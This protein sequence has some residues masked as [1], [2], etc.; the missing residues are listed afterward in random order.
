MYKYI[1]DSIKNNSRC[2][3]KGLTRPQQKAL[4]E[5]VRGL[6]TAGEPILRHIAQDSTKP[7]K[8]QAEKYSYHLG[9]V[10][11]Q[12]KVEELALKQAQKQIRKRKIIAYDL[13]DIAKESARKI[14][15]LSRV[16]DGSKRKTTTGFSLHGVGINGILTKFQVHDSDRFTLNQVRR[17]IVTEISEKLGKKGIWVIDRGNDHKHYFKFLRQDLKADF[18]ARL[19]SNRQVVL[20]KT[21]VKIQVKN[22][23]AGKYAVYL[24]RKNNDHVDLSCEY[25]L[26]I[27]NH[28]EGKE[29]IRLLHSLKFRYSKNQ[30]L[31]MYLQRWGVENIFKR[32]KE[33][34]DLESIRVLKWQKFVNLVALIQ[35]A[36]LVS[37]MM[38]LKIQ[39][40]TNALIIGVLMHYKKFMKLKTLG[41]NLD[42][43]ISFMQKSLKPLLF[44]L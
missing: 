31:N 17:K 15:K 28:L 40:S 30:I 23:Q 37:T 32:V 43:F 38:F 12:E 8:K 27:S 19:K 18:I 20:K 41:F 7:A 36:V 13:T 25:T 39:Q 16:W 29:L 14:E 42:S 6:F 35:L 44:R 26:I 9:N 24:M 21:G 10:Q 5:I 22:L 3:L 33:K 11:I 1:Q 4:S 2:V 34:F